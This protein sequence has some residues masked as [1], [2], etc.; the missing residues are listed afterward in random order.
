MEHDWEQ[1]TALTQ[2]QAFAVER[3]RLVESG[4]AIEAA[5][6]PPPLA[7]L[8]PEDQAFVTA[9]V[10]C[11]G[12]IKQM[13]EWFGISYPTV[14]NRLKAISE[15]L[16]MVEQVPPCVAAPAIGQASDRQAVFDRLERGEI[17]A[18]QAAARLRGG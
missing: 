13:E 2:G 14:K 17:T 7:C 10:H 11:H 16:P 3:V 4:V 9:F 18:A 5:F 8:K 12:S 1:L 6:R 15:C